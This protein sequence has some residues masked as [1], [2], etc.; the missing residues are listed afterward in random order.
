MVTF[1]DVGQGD[2][3]TIHLP[4]GQLIIIDV[5]PRGSPLIDWLHDKPKGIH[6]VVLTHNDADHVGALPGLIGSF[7]D[8]IANFHMLVDRQTR[9]PIFDKTFRCALEGETQ[10]HYQ[11][12]R[13]EVGTVV[14]EDAALQAKLFAVFPTMSGNVLARTPNRTSG[15]LCLEI[16]GRTRIIWP[17]D[18][19]LSRLAAQADGTR[20]QVLF[21]PHHGAPEDYK[22]APAVT[23]ISA[24]SPERAFISVGAKNKYSH[25]RAK[26]LQRLERAG[27]EVVCSEITHTCDPRS[28]REKKQILP[29]HL[30]LG[31]R[32]PR[33]GLACRGVWQLSWNGREFESDGLDQEH[34][35]RIE[36]LRRPQCLRGRKFY[37]KSTAPIA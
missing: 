33:R 26:Y 12:Q 15:I 36:P 23:A 11:I 21:G 16:Q 31:L 19:S 25:P 29:S 10:G 24:V 8:R 6:A 3:S 30:A 28:V 18:S 5:G 14:W 27:C 34:L 9:D 13:L 4:D 1:W 22:G 7:K 32:P 35:R 2:C 20:P 17:G 37:L